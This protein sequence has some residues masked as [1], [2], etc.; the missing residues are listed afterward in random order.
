MSLFNKKHNKEVIK[1]IVRLDK[2]QY[3]HIRYGVKSIM[4]NMEQFM[5]NELDISGYLSG[6]KDSFEITHNKITDINNL[7]INTTE[8]ID[9]FVE[10]TESIE[11]IMVRTDNAINESEEKMNALTGQLNNSNKQLQEVTEKF[12]DFENNFINIQKI[13]EDIS[14]IAANTN[15]L[16]L[17]ASIEAVRA[18]EAGKGFSV[19]AK[20]I[21][22]LANSTTELVSGISKSVGMLYKSLDELRSEIRNTRSALSKSTDSYEEVKKNFVDVTQCS[23]LVKECNG[24]ILNKAKETTKYVKDTISH[25]NEISSMIDTCGD[26]LKILDKKISK[27][28]MTLA[29][30]MDFATQI[31]NIIDDE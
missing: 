1:E 19:V 28:N 20:E 4:K 31:E 29:N 23:N 16:A 8:R 14:D 18:G 2:S 26:S 12:K 21:G 22:Q 24:N 30:I 10:Y 6:I 7:S 3:K 17:N 25:T 5:D 27:G 15:L 13:T 11:N 9:S